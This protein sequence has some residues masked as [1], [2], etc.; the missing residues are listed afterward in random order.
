M[1]RM[2]PT[3]IRLFGEF[4]LQFKSIYLYSAFLKCYTCLISHLD[5]SFLITILKPVFWSTRRVSILLPSWSWS[6]NSTKSIY[7]QWNSAWT[8]KNKQNNV[9]LKRS[10]FAYIFGNN[11]I[12]T[13]IRTCMFGLMFFISIPINA[14][15]FTVLTRKHSDPGRYSVVPR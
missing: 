8:T 5:F 15:V 11:S 1:Y 7:I 3:K 4:R 10:P 12:K 6:F 2:W 13:Q 14:F 9:G